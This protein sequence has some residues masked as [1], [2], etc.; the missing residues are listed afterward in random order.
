MSLV[1][2]AGQLQ[3]HRGGE[4]VP[5]SRERSPRLQRSSESRSRRAGGSMDMRR[6]GTQP[7]ELYRRAARETQPPRAR[8]H[9]DL[10]L[11]DRA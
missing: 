1:A 3:H 8:Y 5:G 2:H 11:K 4:A 6:Q 7:A 9:R 10:R